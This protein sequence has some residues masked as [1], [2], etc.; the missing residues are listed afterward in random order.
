MNRITSHEHTK[1]TYKHIHNIDARIHIEFTAQHILDKRIFLFP[2]CPNC[3]QNSKKKKNSQ[4]S[5]NL[6]FYWSL[7]DECIC[8]QITN[9][10]DSRNSHK[11]KNN[12]LLMQKPTESTTHT[13]TNN[14]K[15][16]RNS[17]NKQRTISMRLSQLKIINNIQ[18][19]NKQTK[20]MYRFFA[21]FKRNLCVLIFFF[22]IIGSLKHPPY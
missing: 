2:I 4:F 5:W 10:S 6:F 20:K 22:C 8:I 17:K 11:Y 18:Q 14:S 1:H 15:Q 13:N 7:L 9:E 3:M 21:H 12:E 19:S 16:W